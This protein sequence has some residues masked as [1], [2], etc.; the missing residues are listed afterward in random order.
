MSEMVR[1]RLCCTKKAGLPD[2]GNLHLVTLFLLLRYPHARCK[3]DAG[4]NLADLLLDILAGSKA[5]GKK[6][7]T[8]TAFLANLDRLDYTKQTAESLYLILALAH[9]LKEG[10][11]PPCSTLHQGQDPA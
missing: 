9:G 5:L 6:R 7:E 10:I 2:G 4:N 3:C 11:I 8:T 1:P